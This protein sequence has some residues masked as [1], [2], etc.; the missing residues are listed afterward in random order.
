MNTECPEYL[1]V[2]GGKGSGG[3]QVDAV[4]VLIEEQWFFLPSLP[5]ARSQFLDNMNS[6]LYHGNVYLMNGY[7]TF[8]CKLDSLVLSCRLATEDGGVDREDM[9]WNTVPNNHHSCPLAFG[10]RLVAIDKGNGTL[11]AYRPLNKS[12]VVVGFFPR[13]LFFSQSATILPNGDLVLFGR[14][15]ML[16]S[17]LK[18]RERES[19]LEPLTRGNLDCMV[20]PLKF[21]WS[22]VYRIKDQPCCPL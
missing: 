19:I 12:W 17:E 2:A 22:H 21:V 7:N 9:L 4:E 5:Q 14:T 8:H 18:G 13:S 1:V 16:K 10:G 20:C 11:Y 15:G 6:V 3:R